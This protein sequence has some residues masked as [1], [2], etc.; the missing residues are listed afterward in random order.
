MIIEVYGKPTCQYC[1]KA[2]YLLDSEEI[3]Y[4]YTDVSLDDVA[5]QKILKDGA[6][7][8]PRVYVDGTCIGGFN[9]LKEMISGN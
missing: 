5:L 4:A 6:T 9:E 7:T 3:P 2:K 8:V 1:D